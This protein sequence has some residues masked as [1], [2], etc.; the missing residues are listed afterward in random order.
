MCP[1]SEI[2]KKLENTTF[3]ILDMFLASGEER[4]TPTLLGPLERANL[5]GLPGD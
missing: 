3:R 5:T 4:K 2:K 1:S